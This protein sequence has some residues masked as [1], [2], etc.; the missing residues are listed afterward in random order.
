MV[1]TELKREFEKRNMTIISAS[2]GAQIL[3]DELTANNI[4]GEHKVQIVAGAMPSRSPQAL[5]PKMRHFRIRRNL[6]VDTNPFLF[7]HRIGNK[8]VLPATCRGFLDH[9]FM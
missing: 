6:S 5:S 2:A 3:V 9:K 8:P 1:T 4:G 7:D